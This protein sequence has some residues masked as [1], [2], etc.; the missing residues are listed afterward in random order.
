MVQRYWGRILDLFFHDL[1]SLVQNHL[2]F[3]YQCV[4]EAKALENNFTT[5]WE[6]PVVNVS[7]H[8]AVGYLFGG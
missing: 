2:R 3:C 8:T 4:N 5:S 1:P 7:T 6:L